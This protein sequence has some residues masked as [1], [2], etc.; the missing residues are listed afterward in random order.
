MKTIE[1]GA[2]FRTDYARWIRG[3]PLEGEFA[4]LLRLLASDATLV[5]HYRD[6]PLQGPWR[7]CRDCH[8]RGDVILIYERGEK[9]IRLVRIGSHSELFGG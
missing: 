3:T 9:S 1:A 4:E 2:R 5:P 8:L 6:H 7:R